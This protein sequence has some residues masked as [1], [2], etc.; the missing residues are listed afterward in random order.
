MSRIVLTGYI[1]GSYETNVYLLHREEEQDTILVDPGACGKQLVDEAEKEGLHIVAILLTH[2]HY[3]HIGSVNEVVKETKARVYMSKDE[4][5]L[6]QDTEANLSAKHNCPVVVYPDYL[7]NDNEVFTVAGISIRCIF[8]PGHTGGSCCYYIEDTGDK[9]N[10]A[11]ILL[12]GDTL[13]QE[14]VGRTDFPTSSTSRLISSIQD[15]L[16][17]L[18]D[19]TMVYPGHGGIT[20]IG[21]EKQFNSM[22]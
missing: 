4:E 14:S 6:A 5:K 22:V 19:E 10:E 8:T 9:E 11:P 17:L 20:S 16:F 15:K 7:L 21:H 1:V 13:F 18:P 2:G 3:D 12:S